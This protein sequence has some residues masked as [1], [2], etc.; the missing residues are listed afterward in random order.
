MNF[1]QSLIYGFAVGLSDILPVSSQA[2]NTLLLK[3][4]GQEGDQP[5]LRLVVHLATLA[6]L[7]YGCQSQILRLLRQQKLA[8][9]PKRRRK[10]PVDMR[11]IM[12][13]RLLRTILIPVLLGFALH[14]KTASWE[15]SL[16]WIAAFLV[17]NGVI[18]FLPALLP[19]GNKDSRA[20]SRIDGLVMGL[21]TT[22]SA[23][24]G[25]SSV[26]AVASIGMLRGVDRAYAVNIA[27]LAN[28]GVTAGSIIFDFITLI[29]NGAG[30]FGFGIL[31]GYLGAALTAFLGA[32]LGIR[33]IRAL[34][35]HT[36][37]DVFAYYCWGMALLAFILFLSV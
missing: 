18:L 14:F 35:V 10:R 34:T 37:L 2:H 25:V 5:V 6:A 19:S 23:F 27:L 13:L 32:W 21:G 7:Y 31:L 11:S 4:F 1:F 26:G 36:G 3:L 33:L 28:M 8:K 15:G 9:I 16:A 22:L 24:P 12:D 29:L 17:V 30:T 20:M